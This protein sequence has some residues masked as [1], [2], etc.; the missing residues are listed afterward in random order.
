MYKL[1]IK[2]FLGLVGLVFLIVL[3][4]LFSLQV[5][6][7]DQNRKAFDRS[8]ETTEM[9]SPIRG[10]ILDRNGVVLAEDKRCYD[11]CLDYGFITQDDRWANEQVAGI[12]RKEGLNES[13]AQAVFSRRVENTWALARQIAADHHVNLDAKLA[14]I[15]RRVQQIRD[16]VGG[17][18]REEKTGQP[19]IAGLDEAVHTAEE[20]I[21]AT[22]TPS[23]TRWYPRGEAAC[24][25]IGRTGVVSLEEQRVRNLS[26]SQADRLARMLQNYLEGDDIGRSGLEK[27]C[28]GQLRGERGYRRSRKGGRILED[29]P[30]TDGRD[31]HTTLDIDLQE[32]LATLM[33]KR[34]VLGSAVVMN[35]AD[36]SILAMVSLPTYDLNRFGE[37]YNTLRN[38]QVDLPLI[39]RAV[40]RRYPIGSTAKPV[41]A[42]TGM[43]NGLS[44]YTRYTCQG[45][46]YPGHPEL[47]FKCD[48]YPGAHNTLELQDAMK[49]SC[50]VYFFHV[51]NYLFNRGSD[52]LSKGLGLFGY[53]DVP[54]TGLPEEVRGNVP[55]RA[56]SAGDAMNWAIGQGQFEATPLHVAN[57]MAAVARGEFVSPKVVEEGG[58]AQVRRQI[59]VTQAQ[60]D[61][62]HAGMWKVVNEP[63][64]TGFKVFRA[65]A[66]PGEKFPPTC[67]KTGTADA[68]PQRIDSNGDGRITTEDQIVREGNMAWFAGY[69]PY[70][71]PQVAFAV[72]VEYVPQGTFG[73]TAAGPIAREL[74]RMCKARGYIR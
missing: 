1:R 30:A 24:H 11:F 20:T 49:V 27:M 4:K 69:A 66:I 13:E 39:H 74:V 33:S 38:N 26:G 70:V 67:G 73:A 46:Y 55:A 7:V 28:E 42:I 58:P 5:L 53:A 71:N 21:G 9:L 15:C 10:R 56:A 18:V 50:N 32:E 52:T 17:P 12:R 35:I 3:G 29:V 43:I 45:L 54:G 57:A 59:P 19:V 2:I 72:V 23:L 61:A 48:V 8:L 40:G 6:G 68:A 16:E 60:L 64:G 51:G 34:G 25:V 47:K 63:G 62:V 41:T 36:G 44:P 37:D 14:S 31:V 22:F 65:E